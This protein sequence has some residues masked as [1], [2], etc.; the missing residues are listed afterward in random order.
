MSAIDAIVRAFVEALIVKQF[1]WRIPDDARID[2]LR[3]YP[4]GS[5]AIDW[6]QP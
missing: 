6:S 3:M 1:S 2:A 4:D 5:F